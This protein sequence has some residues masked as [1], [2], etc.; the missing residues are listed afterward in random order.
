MSLAVKKGNRKSQKKSRGE[1]M[2][3]NGDGRRLSAE[4]LLKE[5]VAYAKKFGTPSMKA[6]ARDLAAKKGWVNLL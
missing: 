6:R 1:K 2:N 3:G 5:D 4:E